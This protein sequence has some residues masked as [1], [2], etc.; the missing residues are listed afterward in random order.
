MSIRSRFWTAAS[1]FALV[2]CAGAPAYAQEAANDEEIVVTAQ[3]REQKVLDV[4]ISVQALS[5][6]DLT[7]QGAQQLRDLFRE[8]AA[9]FKDADSVIL[10]PLYSAGELPI[11]GIDH[12]SLA[13]AIRGAGHGAVLTVDSEREIAPALRSF[14]ASGDIVVCLGAGNSTEWAHALPEWAAMPAWS[15][16]SST[17]CGSTP[18]TPTHTRCGRRPT[19]SP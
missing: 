13:D 10:T 6:N 14:A 15:S 1:M 4:G 7:D 17:A 12:A 11:D 18:S 19:G 5:Q 8:F 3:K 2:W 9:C 16:P